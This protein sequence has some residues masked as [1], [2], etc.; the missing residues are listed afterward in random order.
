MA[1]ISDENCDTCY[2]TIKDTPVNLCH[3]STTFANHQWLWRGSWTSWRLL[4]HNTNKIISTS[5]KLGTSAQNSQYGTSLEFLRLYISTI[6]SRRNRKCSGSI[7]LSS[8]KNVM[9]QQVKKRKLSRLI[10]WVANN[11]FKC[12]LFFAKYNR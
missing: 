11:L 3:P 6:W 7:I 9:G 4:H 2:F 8:V 12:V 1:W 10:W 5:K